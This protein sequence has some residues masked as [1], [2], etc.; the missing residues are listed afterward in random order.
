MFAGLS[1]LTL[2]VGAWRRGAEAAPPAGFL[3]PVAVADTAVPTGTTLAIPLTVDMGGVGSLGSFQGILRFEP[4]VLTYVDLQVGDFSG[5]VELNTDSASSGVLRFAG[6]STDTLLHRGA[7][8]LVVL[9]VDVTGFG[10][11]VVEV[12]PDSVRLGLAGSFTDVTNGTTVQSGSVT[13]DPGPL[14]MWLRPDPAGAK[15]NV[16]TYLDLRV[17]LSSS[18]ADPGALE[19]TLTLDP[20]V[21]R[22]DSAEVG[23][24]GGSLTLN[25]APQTDSGF[26]RWA[27]LGADPLPADTM[28]VARFF[29]TPL[30]PEGSSTVATPAVT[31]AVNA[32]NLAS[33]LPFLDGPDPWRLDVIGGLWGDASLSWRDEPTAAPLT[34]FD[35]LICLSLVIARDVSAYDALGC[36]VAPDPSSYDGTITSL[37]ALVILTHVVGLDTSGYRVGQPR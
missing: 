15:Q 35:A 31:D 25:T 28:L 20:L 26:V 27:A 2:L 17:D 5:S 30:A 24:F 11:E 29:L 36:D 19:G 32:P 23:D 10:G 18:I 6:A 37:D 8:S 21:A 12:A 9:T 14:R 16:P 33:L 4:G 22:V 1:A 7:F 13:V 3:I 34:A